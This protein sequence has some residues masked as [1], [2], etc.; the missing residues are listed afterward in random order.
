MKQIF[1]YFILYSLTIISANAQNLSLDELIR[2]RGKDIESANTYLS[3]KGWQ[4][5]DA[6]EETQNQY[7]T[8]TWSYGKQQYTNRSKAFIKLMTADGYFNQIRYITIYK[9]HFNLIKSRIAYYKL[10]RLSS[11]AKD[12]YIKSTYIGS[13]YIIETTTSTDKYTSI[14]VYGISVRKKPD[15]YIPQ[16]EIESSNTD[17]NQSGLNA[18]PSKDTLED[19]KARVNGK[20]YSPPTEYVCVWTT[21]KSSIVLQDPNDIFSQLKTIPNGAEVIIVDKLVDE[22]HP[23]YLIWI[24]GIFGYMENIDFLEYR[25]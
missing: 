17:N 6:S 20:L 2:L 24:D 7:S 19:Y 3:S 1:A 13:N 14:P 5:D 23:C 25:G 10:T 4:F 15:V 9:E 12:G 18:P 16:K 8:T 22:S 21:K 11:E